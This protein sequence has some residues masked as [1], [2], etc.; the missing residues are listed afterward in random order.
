MKGY[1]YYDTPNQSKLTSVPNV[2]TTKK[3]GNLWQQ[4]F[5]QSIEKERLMFYHGQYEGGCGEYW[6][7]RSVSINA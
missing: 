4:T 1:L 7:F 2:T 6:Q 5:R 3:T